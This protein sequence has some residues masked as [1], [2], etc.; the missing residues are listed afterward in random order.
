MIDIGGKTGSK[1]FLP[2]ILEI[3]ALFMATGIASTALIPE[4]NQLSLEEIGGEDQEHF[5]KESP[6]KETSSA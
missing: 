5:I 2:H 4:T 6:N 3:F 1:A